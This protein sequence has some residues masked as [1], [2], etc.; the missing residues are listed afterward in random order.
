[1][2]MDESQETSY[3]IRDFVYFDFERVRSFVAQAMGGLVSESSRGQS[4]QTAGKAGVS[5]G[6]PGLLKGTGELDYRYVRSDQET[7]SLH[8]G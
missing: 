3:T 6:I 5:G 7:R 4:H 8:H 2:G 1:M